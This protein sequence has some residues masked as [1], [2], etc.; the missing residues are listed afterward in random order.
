MHRRRAARPR[1]KPC[2]AVLGLAV[3]RRCLRMGLGN[4]RKSAAGTDPASGYE[5][6]TRA[7]TGE[8]RTAVKLGKKLSP[9]TDDN[10]SERSAIKATRPEMHPSD[11]VPTHTPEIGEG[12]GAG[13][14]IAFTPARRRA[15][16]A[17][18]LGRGQRSVPERSD[19]FF[20][21]LRSAARTPDCGRRFI[22]LLPSLARRSWRLVRIG[23]VL[24]MTASPGLQVTRLCCATATLSRNRRPAAYCSLTI[25]A[26]SIMRNL[27][28]AA[29]LA[30]LRWS[31]ICQAAQASDDLR[32]VAATEGPPLGFSL[33]L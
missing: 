7:A 24:I 17:A 9:A 11:I 3:G 19:V 2:P 4:K 14:F 13:K 25:V 30:G 20:K 16:R 6:Q 21:K 23:P 31:F 10:A 28:S 27:R 32:H 15:L 22:L 8:P 33:G 5:P 18:S 12:P 26:L 1:E 29:L